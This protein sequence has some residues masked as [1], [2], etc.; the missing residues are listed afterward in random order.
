MPTVDAVDPGD[1]IPSFGDLAPVLDRLADVAN[2]ELHDPVMI[3]V[4]GWDDGDWTA[5][6]QHQF[7][8]YQGTEWSGREVIRYDA[9]SEQFHARYIEE[10]GETGASEILVER[11][12]ESYPAPS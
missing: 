6:A 3:E 4:K 2:R 12:L 9:D 1:G 8:S 5:I 10:H 7:G 11:A